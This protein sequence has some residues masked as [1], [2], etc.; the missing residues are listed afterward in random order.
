MGVLALY[1]VNKSGGLVFNQDFSPT[2]PKLSTN[3]HLQLA[4]TFF[5]CAVASFVALSRGKA[6][7]AQSKVPSQVAG[8]RYPGV[9]SAAK[10]SRR[11]H[12]A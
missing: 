6:A 2:A 10:F 3:A 11:N 4:S 8:N 7:M 9:S 1:V 12:R 5:G